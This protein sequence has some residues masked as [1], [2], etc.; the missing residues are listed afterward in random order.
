MNKRSLKKFISEMK[1][2][3]ELLIILPSG[4]ALVYFALYIITICYK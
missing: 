1:E 4:T 3:W 2:E